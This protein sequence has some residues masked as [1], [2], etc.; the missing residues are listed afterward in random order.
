M[1]TALAKLSQQNS[2][3]VVQRNKIQ[4]ATRVVLKKFPKVQGLVVPGLLEDGEGRTQHRRVGY[5]YILSIKIGKILTSIEAGYL[6]DGRLLY[7]SLH[8][9]LCWKLS[10]IEGLKKQLGFQMFSQ[11]CIARKLPLTDLEGKLEIYS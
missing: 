2:K 10:I 5:N 4:K 1:K 3:V 8:F 7:S 6:K 9:G 11:I